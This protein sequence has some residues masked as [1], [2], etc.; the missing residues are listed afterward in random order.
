MNP[1]ERTLLA[2]RYRPARFAHLV[3]QESARAILQ[4]LVH[5][6][7]LP[8]ALLF[9]GQSGTGKTSAAR[10]L[11]AALNCTQPTNGDCCATCPSCVAVRNGHSHSVHE[12]DAA[13]NGGVA[14]IRALRQLAEYASDGPWRVILLDEAHSLSREAF[15][16]LLKVLEEPPARTLFVL[17]T[18]EPDKIME[19]VRS[20]C[21]PIFFRPVAHAAI[22]ERLTYVDR[23]EHLDMPTPVLA[24]IAEHA[25][26]G[27][28]DALMLL[29]QATRTNTCDVASLRSLTG[30]TDLPAQIVAALTRADHRDAQRLLRDFFTTSADIGDLIA[31]MITDLQTR[32]AAHTLTHARMIAA[33][34]LLWDARSV[35]SAPARVARTQVE[36]LVTLLYAV[37]GQQPTPDPPPATTAPVKPAAPAPIPQV[38]P[39]A[40]A[41]GDGALDLDELAAL[42]SSD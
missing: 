3:G 11:A 2:L 1:E 36:A 37:L 5:A 35:T 16:A 27:V 19:T 34:R 21:M 17:V 33:T 9:G 23:V 26:G 10:L 30:R 7:D 29:D 12:I 25:D 40:P 28:R 13:T 31:A 15:N 22:V 4:A 39:D 42:L 8:P 6:Q 38:K 24:E 41:E 32:F 20:R 18:T 14:D